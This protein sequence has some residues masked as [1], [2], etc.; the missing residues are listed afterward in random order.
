MRLRLTYEETE[1]LL[2]N[3]AVEINRNGFDILIEKQP[4]W[5][6]NEIGYDITIVNPFDTMSLSKCC[7]ENLKKNRGIIE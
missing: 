6:Q 2:K 5:R 1:K 3:G 4:E 7:V